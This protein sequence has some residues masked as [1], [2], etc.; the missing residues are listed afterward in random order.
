[1]EKAKFMDWAYRPFCNSD[2]I[3]RIFNV[4]NVEDYLLKLRAEVVVDNMR[5]F[6]IIRNRYI[7]NEE[8][9]D[10]SD[11]FSEEEF[12]DYIL[13]IPT[14]YAEKAN[15]TKG[16]IFSNDANGSIMRTDFGDII[17]IS[18]ALRY[19]L[20]YMNLTFLDFGIEVPDSVRYRSLMIGI[21]TM[22]K[23]ETLDFEQ[24][25]RGIIPE[26]LEKSINHIV[27]HQ[28]QFI[29]GHELS[30]HFLNHLDKSK[31]V[32]RSFYRLFENEKSELDENE[33][34]NYSQEQEFE[35]DKFTL[36]LLKETNSLDSY[37]V[38][39]AISFFGY[40][41]IFESVSDYL[42]PASSSYQSHPDP[43]KRY[44]RIIKD[45]KEY[46]DEKFIATFIESVQGYKNAIMKEI[47]F[48]VDK[49]EMYGSHYLAE[50]NTV[51]RGRQLIDREDYY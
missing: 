10:F 38:Q 34:Y 40:L 6:R 23:T 35:A 28:L 26:E 45:Y 20:F 33:F 16:F 48:E 19:F 3:K 43:D 4:S 32:K 9:W 42:F 30:H 12:E 22:L 13:S 1:M 17:C 41:E 31:T 27:S 7:Q 44:E 2:D 46:I 11:H 29:I 8:T 47:G 21:R 51:W 14:E 24:D 49:Y 37:Y 18:E 5:L 36:N 39:G 15:L 25:P 50:P